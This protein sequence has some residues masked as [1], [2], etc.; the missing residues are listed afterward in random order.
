MVD[1]SK[2]KAKSGKESVSELTKMF[3]EKSGGNNPKNENGDDER[4]WQP[5][6]DK[7]GNGYAV[8]RF[9]PPIG[10]EEDKFVKTYSHGF[11]GPTGKWYIEKSLTTINQPDPVTDYNNKLWA[12]NKD[13]KSSERVQARAQKRKLYYIAN[14]YVVT[15]SGNPENNGKNF[16]FKFGSKIFAKIKECLLPEF[17]EEGRTIEHD[18]YS[19]Q[20]TF[21]PF[22][23][24][25][26]ANL[27]LK[28][29]KVEGYRNYDKS[30]FAKCSPLSKDDDELQEIHSKGYS[31]KEFVDPK[32]FKSYE[33]LE[34][35]FKL[36]LGEEEHENTTSTLREEAPKASK[37]R[38]A[39]KAAESKATYDEDDEDSDAIFRKLSEE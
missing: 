10:D 24:W 9:M 25:N 17:D 38:S 21:D 8:I 7:A 11:Q 16:L 29:R 31:L 18:D 1:F 27:L 6:V 19:P 28:I 22:D 4:F 15:D 34:K 5:T 20:N 23:L 36:V 2:L 26:G 32:N 35:R 3:A 39:P 33:E 37:T 13:D 30:E 14:I 12:A